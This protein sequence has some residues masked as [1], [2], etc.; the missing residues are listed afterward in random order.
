VEAAKLEKK[1][2]KMEARLAN[3]RNKAQTQEEKSQAEE[4]LGALKCIVVPCGGCR[5]TLNNK[6]KHN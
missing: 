4:T 5:Y 1:E 3:A 6:Q 2:A